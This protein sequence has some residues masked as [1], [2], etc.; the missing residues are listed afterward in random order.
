MLL[1]SSNIYNEKA[2]SVWRPSQEDV[3]NSFIGRV[4]TVSEIDKFCDART[5]LVKEK[6]I[7]E[8]PFIV[9]VGPSFSTVSHYELVM[10]KGMSYQFSDIVSAIR[11]TY[12]LYWLLDSS[13]PRDCDMVWMFI[14]R[15]MYKMA[16]KQDKAALPLKELFV[17]C[18][19][20]IDSLK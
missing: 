1:R 20:E 15:A 18:N 2:K 19:I 11:A 6:G 17:E 8:Q 16:S 9:A 14:Q 4:D 10:Q 7:A 13:Y 3:R 12:R 5:K